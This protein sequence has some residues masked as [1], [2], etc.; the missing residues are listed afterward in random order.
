MTGVQT[1]ALPISGVAL[2]GCYS[3][4]H[5][6]YCMTSPNIN[7]S[8]VP[9]SA[10][11]SY[12]RHLHSDYPSYIT[13]HVDVSA[14]GGA[15]WTSVFTSPAGQF[16]DDAAWTFQSYNITAQKS[17]QTRV[18]FCYSAGSVAVILGGGWNVD[19]VQITDVICQ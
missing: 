9:G 2:G 4:N 12:W 16:F 1:C 5:G 10:Y 18:R 7:L 8:G 19:D 13:N 15:T 11:L 17:A 3:L 14:D 6:D